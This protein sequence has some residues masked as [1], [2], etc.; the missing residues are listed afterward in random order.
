MDQGNSSGNI[1]TLGQLFKL[2]NP[3]SPSEEGN[4]EFN[5]LISQNVIVLAENFSLS[6]PQ[7]NLLNRG[8]TFVP[9]IN[10]NKN[11]KLQFQ[12]DLQNYHRKI[13]LATYFGKDKLQEVQPCTATSDWTPSEDKLPP[14]VKIL[15]KED[16]KDF[17]KYFKF[18]EEKTNISEEEVKA[19]QELMRNKNIVIKKADKGSAVVILGREQYIAEANRQL[20]DTKYVGF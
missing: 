16:Q 4:K 18:Y 13:K 19:L 15:I 9:T 20:S 12:W 5:S 17:N 2:V 10:L 7:W 14:E 1:G 6:K 8:L 11:Q 3:L